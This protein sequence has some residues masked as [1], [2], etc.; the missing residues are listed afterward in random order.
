MFEFSKNY[1]ELK[2]KKA[3]EAVHDLAFK[4]FLREWCYCNPKAPDNKEIC[5][6]LVCFDKTLIIV[7][8]KDITFTGDEERYFRKA[9]EAPVK[10]VLGAERKLSLLDGSLRLTTSTGFQHDFN[11]SECEHV[12]RLVLSVGDG[13]VPFSVVD[14]VGGKLVHVFDR[15]IDVVLNELDTISDFARYLRDK[16]RLFISHDDRFLT[17]HREI[18]LLGDY[19]F[20]GRSFAHFDG[21]DAVFMEEGIWEALIQRPEYIRK[22]KEDRISYFWDN[23]VDVAGTCE[24]PDYR[25][26]AREL[27]RPK[28][29]H[30]R[31]LANAFLT[32]H[33]EA[34][35]TDEPFLRF[36]Q[37]DGVSYVF[38][39]SSAN[40]E[41][42]ERK[43]QLGHLCV[44]ARDQYRDNARVIGIATEFTRNGGH[45]FEFVFLDFPTWTA[46]NHDK[47]ERL[48][49]HYQVLLEPR[50]TRST[51]E[52]F[53]SSDA[54]M[55]VRQAADR[56]VVRPLP[57][58]GRNSPCPCGSGKKYKKC[59]GA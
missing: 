35:N 3:E 31:W 16:E 18:D 55:P 38:L 10:Q 56:T 43:G 57:K 21:Y 40:L 14:E 49:E 39:F 30:R 33:E 5:D 59:C 32:A 48:N 44:V 46:E 20:K 47:A 26:I 23:L 34:V 2:G 9:I 41:R 22:E 52:E 54:A 13:N 6:L 58:V 17:A 27:S 50:R 29:F 7:Q 37:C 19:V 42:V 28:R 15:T 53:P 4:S 36:T 51:M 25:E 12:H 24:A 45:T 11:Y 1:F 8:V